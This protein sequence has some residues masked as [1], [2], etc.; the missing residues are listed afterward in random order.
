MSKEQ[1]FLTRYREEAEDTAKLFSTTGQGRQERTAV[2]GLLEALSIPYKPDELIK[3]GPEPADVWFGDARFQV[4]ELLEPG[5]KR[6][7]EVRDRAERAKEAKR[8]DD[9]LERSAFSA[10]RSRPRRSSAQS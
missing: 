7:A 9:L 6:N 10:G 1:E 5:G 8:I 3:A 2:A 4:T